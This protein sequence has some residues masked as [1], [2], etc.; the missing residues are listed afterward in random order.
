MGPVLSGGVPTVCIQVACQ[1]GRLALRAELI[2]RGLVDFDGLTEMPTALLAGQSA[3]AAGLR[4]RW[5][6]FV[7]VDEYQDIDAV[8]YDLLRAISGDGAGLTAI[9]DPDQAIY[10]FRGADAGIFGRFAADF[11]A[12]TT[13]E[14]TRNYRSTRPSPG[15]DHA[16]DRSR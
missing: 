3:I 11:P 9:G 12:A 10:G 5:W 15:R 2:A 16:A 14:L 7:S 6:P 4:S 13:V 1:A 8:Q